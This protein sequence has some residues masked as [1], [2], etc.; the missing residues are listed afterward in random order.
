M[1]LSRQSGNLPGNEL[2]NNLSG[3]AQLQVSQVAEPLWTDPS[4]KSR[5]NFHELI[6]TLGEGKKC[7]QGMN[8]QTFSQNSH[9]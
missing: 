2:T 1:H 6:S 8:D 3:N 9:T 4:L 5:I 7:W